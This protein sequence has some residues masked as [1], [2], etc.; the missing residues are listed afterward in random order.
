M[1]KKMLEMIIP[2]ILQDQALG[3]DHCLPSKITSD[4][5]QKTVLC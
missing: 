1:A 5:K 2:P 4:Q 3:A